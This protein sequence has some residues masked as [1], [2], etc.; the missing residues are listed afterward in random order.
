MN[1]LLSHTSVTA[2]AVRA[3]LIWVLQAARLEAQAWA[4]EYEPSWTYQDNQGL[5][6]GPFQLAE[7]KAMTAQ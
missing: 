3:L 6:Q 1:P 5:S 4:A 7:L 2:I